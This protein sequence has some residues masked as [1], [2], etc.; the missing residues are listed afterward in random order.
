MELTYTGFRLMEL[1]PAEEYD[2]LLRGLRRLFPAKPYGRDEVDRFGTS[3]SN[4]FDGGWSNVGTLV[5]ENKW[6]GLMDMRV[7]PELP[8]EV[9][10]V[11]I[12]V[13]KVL[14]SAIVLSLDAHL[15]EEASSILRKLHSRVYLPV[16]TFSSFTPWRGHRTGRSTAPAEWSLQDALL[17]WQR[18]LHDGI[19]LC[20]SAYL[21]GFFSG[22]GRL[23]G[24]LPVIDCFAVTG[25]PGGDGDIHTRVGSLRTWLH[26]AAVLPDPSDLNK[27]LRDDLMFVWEERR[28]ERLS[29]P[30]RFVQFHAVKPEP[31]PSKLQGFAALRDQLDAVLPYICFLE[32]L[33]RVTEQVEMLRIRVYRTL[34]GARWFGGRFRA[35]MKLNDTIQREA[36]FVS[37]LS[38]ELSDS[39]AW[40][41]REAEVL[42]GMTQKLGR[43]RKEY[44]LI[45]ALNGTL[46]FRLRRVRR[47]LRLISI[48]FADYVSRRNVRLMY[49][50]QQQ[51]WFLSVVA[52]FA[53]VVGIF[54]NWCQL[55]QVFASIFGR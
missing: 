46:S 54:T 55:R 51:V 42:R 13:H 2:T 34:A 36:M 27:Y 41:K 29:T 19:R 53:A 32:A 14:P 1:F 22:S 12:S 31:D 30:Y 52:A 43:D 24:T 44:V 39:M 49:G 4:L 37:R 21:P 48:S 40:L 18:S 23:G 50:L 17:R 28:E 33:E 6:L 3:A 7:E 38:L 8:R 35:D 47:H 45:D 10:Y 15:S 16:S 25:V 20:V 11:D 26:S 5:R 9:E